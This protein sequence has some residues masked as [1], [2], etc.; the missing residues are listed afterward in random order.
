M[1]K[2]L[3][4]IYLGN[5]LDSASGSAEETEKLAAQ[6]AQ[7]QQAGRCWE[8]TIERGDRTKGRILTHTAT[9]QP[10]GIV[11]D[12]TWQLREGDVFETSHG[13]LVIVHLES[14]FLMALKFDHEAHNSPAALVQLGC[15]LGNQHWPASVQGGV[16]YVERVADGAVMAKIVSEMAATLGIEG[17]QITFESKPA[18][19]AI[20]FHQHEHHSH[21]H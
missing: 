6:V 5:S 2:L 16:V 14:Q 20:A 19:E 17:L 4:Q 1:Q 3:A 12:R 13:E 21:A 15:A 8:V 18:A 10:V 7:M 9:G 11:K